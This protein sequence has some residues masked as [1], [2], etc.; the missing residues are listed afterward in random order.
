MQPMPMPMRQ[1]QIQPMLTQPTTQKE[2][3]PM[4]CANLVK[5]VVAEN[6]YYKD[7]VGTAIFDFV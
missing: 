7:A 4:R 3:Y 6:P 2:A 5:A 1:V